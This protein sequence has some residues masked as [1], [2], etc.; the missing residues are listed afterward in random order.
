MRGS[1][2]LE[3]DG[4]GSGLGAGGAGSGLGA[5]GSSLR[6][7]AC[8]LQDQPQQMPFA[9][10]QNLRARLV[11]IYEGAPRLQ[12]GSGVLR[13]SFTVW[14]LKKGKVRLRFEG[15]AEVLVGQGDWVLMPPGV[16]ERQFSDDAQIL[17]LFFDAQWNTGENWLD[18]TEPIVFTAAQ[19]RGWYRLAL[20]MLKIVRQNFATAYNGLPSATATFLE[21][22]QLQAHFLI[23]LNGLVSRAA[24]AGVRTRPLL[25]EDDRA[26]RIREYLDAFALHRPFRVEQLAEKFN[27]SISQLGRVYVAHFGCSPREHFGQRRLHRARTLLR[28][29][30]AAVKEV[31]YSLGFRYAS[32]FSSWFREHEGCSPL[33]YRRSGGAKG[34]GQERT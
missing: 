3:F 15:L 1:G 11:W 34:I 22:A 12:Q 9:L 10:W 21:Y 29:G 28:T 4:A 7:Q 6:E 5:G 20:P 33:Q 18:L 14:R 25:I 31:A 26:L 19:T 13:K 8:R 2:K 23:W 16:D 24:Q 32:Q 17:S 27:M 30:D